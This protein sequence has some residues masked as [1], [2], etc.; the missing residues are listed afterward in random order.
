MSYFMRKFA[1]YCER[2]EFYMKN[3]LLYAILLML[4]VFALHAEKP[5]EV[6]P[7]YSW[8]ILEP[9]GLRQESTIDTLFQNYHRRSVPAMVSSAYAT[10]GNLG[11]EGL[12]LIYFDRKN[13]S[14][15]FFQDALA[16]WM[17]TLYEMTFYNTRIPMTLLSYNTGGGKENS[18]DRLNGIF[19]GNINK[20][21]QVGALLDYLYSKGSYNYQ[22]DK[23]LSWG[24]NGSYIGDRYEFQGYFNHYNLLNKENGGIVDDLYITDPAEIQGGSTK[25]DHKTIPTNLT[26]SH[27][28]IV[29]QRLLL[30][31]RYKVG[32]YKEEQI[33]DTTTVKTYVPVSSFIWTLKYDASKHIFK[34]DVLTEDQ[35]FWENRYIN[36]NGTDD[37]T[38]YWSL[39]NTFGVSLLEGFNKYAKAGLAAYVTHQI[40]SY[41]Q[42]PDTITGTEY[43]VGLTPNPFPEI[44]ANEKQNLLWVGAQLTKQN[45]TYLTY[46][47]TGEIGVAGPAAG[48]VK[49][50]GNINTRFPLLGDTVALTAYGK[51]ENIAPPYLYNNYVS[52]HF[53]WKND[54]SKI[55]KFRAGGILNIPLTSTRLNIGV[56]NVQN[57]IYFDKTCM[58]VQHGGSVQVFSA[59]QNQHLGYKAINWDNEL[60]YQTSTEESVIPLP[61]FAV[62][63]NLY[64]G[65][66]VAR[67]LDVQFG[68]DCTYYTKYKSVNYQ[69]AT[70]TFYNQDEI[71]CGGFPYMN[72]YANMK[73]SKVRFYVMMS[74]INQ[75]LT[76][77]NYFSM[78]H[79]PLNPRRFLLGLT[80]DFAN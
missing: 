28:K 43:A 51:F 14:D 19:S 65:F 78:P 50:N 3:I 74:H 69:P 44:K 4:S 72:V 26:K 5:Q 41:T 80:I 35:S 58:P 45:G 48:E 30:N 68:V 23:D 36:P 21:A 49:I 75:G 24:F 40:R 62:Y 15:F 56:E 1:R 2:K 8:T 25:V 76:D 20:N 46:N 6:Q 66:K 17:P 9:L 38:Q 52:N 29:A 53:I 12:N 57:Y 16:A 33:D 10:T 54:F 67:V 73:L 22:A 7:S 70:M 37:R 59:T 18:Q 71:E 55:R 47:V 11:A 42:A 34:N 63:S 27:S 60:T 32:F 39:T 31:N 64:L 61:K 77:D 79:Y 13:T